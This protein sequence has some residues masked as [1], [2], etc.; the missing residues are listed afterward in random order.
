[1]SIK[2]LKI[3]VINLNIWYACYVKSDSRNS[4]FLKNIFVVNKYRNLTYIVRKK[5]KKK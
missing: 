1:M 5:C 3:A 4:K 2:Y